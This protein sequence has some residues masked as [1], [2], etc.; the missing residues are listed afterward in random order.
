MS[1]CR[2]NGIVLPVMLNEANEEPLL[3]EDA[4][5]MEDASLFVDRRAE[6]GKWTVSMSPQFAAYAAAFRK[7]LHGDGH[8]WSFDTS[9]YSSKG[10]GPSATAGSFAIGSTAPPPWLGAGRLRVQDTGFVRFTAL[11]ATSPW[12]ASFA[13]DVGN[14]VWIHYIINSAGQKWV[15]GVR[16]DAAS[17]TFFS[18]T[19][20]VVELTS[21]LGD[22][23][24]WDELIVYPFAFPTD[25]PP[26][27]YAF[28][29]PASG[30]KQV[31]A[32]RQLKLDGDVVDDATV[33]TIIAR[34]S[35]SSVVHAKASGAKAPVRKL[36]V[37]MEE[38]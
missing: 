13:R 6:K 32:L 23:T 22:L 12:T 34:V 4:V 26:Q 35:G 1:F 27:L 11:S 20:G 7:L 25:W 28:Q 19:A 17:T 10:L 16:N 37:E 14:N 33:R 21:D 8:Y 38:V 24:S 30:N 36:E 2:I 31:G 3:V 29:N 9:L 18:V 15:D 5:R